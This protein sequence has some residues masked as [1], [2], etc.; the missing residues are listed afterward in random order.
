MIIAV[1]IF[2]YIFTGMVAG[3]LILN[4]DGQK[5]DLDDRAD[6]T[7]LLFTTI[8]WPLTLVVEFVYYIIWKM[9]FK[10]I[11]RFLVGVLGAKK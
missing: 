8:F 6:I 2:L 5:I 7:F 3:V 10:N 1:C 9:V 11:F 4:S